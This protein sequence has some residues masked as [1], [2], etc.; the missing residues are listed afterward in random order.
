MRTT[1]LEATDLRDGDVI[2]VA[3]ANGT[4]PQPRKV[5]RA[6]TLP[7]GHGWPEGCPQ[8]VVPNVRL[9]LAHRAIVVGGDTEWD[10][11]G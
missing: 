2:M 11:V 9:E 4:H 10:V 7:T 1:S 6:T 3:D 8:Y 5:Y